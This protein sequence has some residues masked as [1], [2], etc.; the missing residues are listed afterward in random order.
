[1]DL[2]FNYIISTNSASTP[3][4]SLS[5]SAASLLACEG[6]SSAIC[7]GDNCWMVLRVVRLSIEAIG[8]SLCATLPISFIRADSEVASLADA[9]SDS[10]FKAEVNLDIYSSRLV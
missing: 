8:N 4:S 5:T 10:I 7:S 3:R 9:T 2:W 1:M 6:S